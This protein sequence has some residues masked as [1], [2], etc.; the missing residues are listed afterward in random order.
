MTILL[1]LAATAVLLLV[2]IMVRQSLSHG[3]HAQRVVPIDEVRRLGLMMAHEV[4]NPLGIILN[5]IERVRDR[6]AQQSPV[7]ADELDGIPEQIARINQILG[8]YLTCTQ[9][10]LFWP[11][12]TDFL[13]LL[14]GIVDDAYRMSQRQ[15]V[16]RIEGPTV[17][18]PEMIVDRGKMRQ[19]FLNLFRNSI[20]ATP[21]DRLV[22][23]AVELR[24]SWSSRPGLEIRLRDTAVL[25]TE[26]PLP[27]LLRLDL[28]RKTDGTGI[29]LAICQQLVEEH[30]GGIT[31]RREGDQLRV[32]LWFPFRSSEELLFRQA[33]TND[34]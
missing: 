31:L 3:D 2:V 1:L 10:T 23:I 19:I 24:E 7:S 32:S 14:Q 13:Q 26:T 20:E 11:E 12:A 27:D 29:G 4:R 9:E 16:I 5:T 28:Q 15:L 22:E 25:T 6:L 33:I 21:V 18:I 17:D 34:V 8:N 30:G